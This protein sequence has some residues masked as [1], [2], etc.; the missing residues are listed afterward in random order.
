MGPKMNGCYHGK[1]NQCRERER[2][3]FLFERAGGRRRKN[4]D[5]KSF[6]VTQ[7]LCLSFYLLIWVRDQDL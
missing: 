6:C 5:Y 1:E 2:H 3:E 4:I 7:D